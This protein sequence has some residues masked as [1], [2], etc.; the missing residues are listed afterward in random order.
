MSCVHVQGKCLGKLAAVTEV[1]DVR[2]ILPM[3]AFL[4]VADV[5]VSDRLHQCID[6][7]LPV[8]TG[9]MVS[10]R[11]RTQGAEVSFALQ[12]AVEKSLDNGSKGAIAQCDVQAHYDTVNGLKVTNWLN[13]KGAD[14]AL[15]AAALRMQLVC[16][17]SLQSGAMNIVIS[18]RSNGSLTGSRVAGAWGRVP[19]E[20]TIAKRNSSWKERGWRTTGETLTVASYVDNLFALGRDADAAIA[21]CE[22]FGKHLAADWGQKIKPSSKQ[23]LVPKGGDAPKQAV[24]W[25][26]CTTFNVLGNTVQHN[27]ETDTSWEA[28]KGSVRRAWFCTVKKEGARELSLAA[29]LKLMNTTIKPLVMF[30]TTG[31]PFG[32]TRSDQI[33]RLQ[34]SLIQQVLK[35]PRQ[36]DEDAIAYQKRKHTAT[37]AALKTTSDW[38]HTAATRTLQWN[39]HNIRNN[40]N[41]LWAA[42]IIKV[43]T[44]AELAE[45]RKRRRE[46]GLPGLGRRAWP[47]HVA[48][49]W[50]QSV[51]NAA[52]T[53]A[54]YTT[55]EQPRSGQEE[56]RTSRSRAQAEPMQSQSRVEAE[57]PQNEVQVSSR[58]AP[59][60]CSSAELE[61]GGEL[62]TSRSR[63]TAEEGLRNARPRRSMTEP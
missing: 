6:S 33:S 18:N 53:M 9:V 8:P 59:L 61:L 3:P 60:Q 32:K 48:Q 56:L 13:A 46:H 21:T 1:K 47:G 49:R 62:R 42:E 43:T 37:T 58:R 2:A 27:A 10:A 30:K 34:R 52:A 29:N 7:F 38:R 11:P 5:L 63:A 54:L 36:E 28:T 22:D 16:K 45:V 31:M 12:L 57:Q 55:A 44:A 41:R 17:V 25:E 14:K 15:T 20:A 26:A 19:V 35:L 39:E 40:S 4:Q 24:G 51:I 50:E 23:F